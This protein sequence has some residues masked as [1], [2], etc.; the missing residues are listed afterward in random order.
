MTRGL[1]NH[2]LLLNGGFAFVGLTIGK[3]S[4]TLPKCEGKH[5]HLRV[6]VSGYRTG[7]G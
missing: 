7:H 5:K 3:I 2:K 1:R 6:S 4:S